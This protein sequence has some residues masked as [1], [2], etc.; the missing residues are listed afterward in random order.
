MSLKKS[1]HAFTSRFLSMD[2]FVL[3]ILIA[4]P[5][6]ISAPG[7][8]PGVIN[9]LIWGATYFCLLCWLY[10]IAYKASESLTNQGWAT[11]IFR[12]T[13]LFMFSTVCWFVLLLFRT[14]KVTT[15]Y[16]G[17][18]INYY[19]PVLFQAAFE[20]SFLL[21]LILAAKILVSAER[22]KDATF[23]E[24]FSTFLLLIFFPI[25]VWFIQPRVQRLL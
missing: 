9:K 25:G 7:L 2:R 13:C 10:A 14:T 22:Q 6:T 4:F 15:H 12:A 24:F 1:F 19:E 20:A 5:I 3:F 17:V 16:H 21:V 18:G 11:N 23:R 8:I